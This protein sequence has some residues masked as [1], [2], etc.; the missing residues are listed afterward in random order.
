MTLP[1]HPGTI[2]YV[3]GNTGQ[4]V[5]TARVE[6][7]PEFARYAEDATGQKVPVVKVVAHTH[8]NQR[9]I[10]EMAA[11]GTVLRSTVQVATGGAQ[12]KG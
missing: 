8:G 3:D 5:K 2:V 9:T 12:G 7:V 4:V 6:D 1:T 11:D 10:R